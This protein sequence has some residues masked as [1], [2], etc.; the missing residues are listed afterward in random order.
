MQTDSYVRVLCQAA[1]CLLLGR[2]PQVAVARGRRL[3][4]QTNSCVRNL[5]LAAMCLSHKR[6]KAACFGG[7]AYLLAVVHVVLHSPLHPGYIAAGDPDG[8]SPCLNPS[9]STCRGDG[10]AAAHT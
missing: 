7:R 4:M 8:R 2:R 1:T 9:G 6:V 3:L 10:D 5:C